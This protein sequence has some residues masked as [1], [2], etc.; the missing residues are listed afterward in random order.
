MKNP[1]TRTH[2][3]LYSPNSGSDSHTDEIENKPSHA[4]KVFFTSDALPAA[5]LEISGLE[6]RLRIC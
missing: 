4:P 5:T 6:D 1:R 3:S 2:A